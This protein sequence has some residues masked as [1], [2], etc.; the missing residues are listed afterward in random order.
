MGLGYLGDR[1]LR[2]VANFENDAHLYDWGPG[3]T[4][5]LRDACAAAPDTAAG[6]D[7]HAGAAGGS[8]KSAGGGGGGGGSKKNA[9]SGGGGS[10]ESAGSG[11]GGSKESAGS[12]QD[13]AADTDG[14]EPRPDPSRAA[15]PGFLKVPLER[16]GDVA[17]LRPTVA[18]VFINV[19]KGTPTAVAKA[20]LR[21]VAT[22]LETPTPRQLCAANGLRTTES[23]VGVALV[24]EDRP[25]HS[26]AWRSSNGTLPP[27]GHRVHRWISY[28]GDVSADSI[29]DSAPP[30]AQFAW[31]VVHPTYTRTMCKTRWI[32]TFQHATAM[33]AGIFL[34]F[35]G[36]A[37][38]LG[39]E[40]LLAGFPRLLGIEPLPEWA[41]DFRPPSRSMYGG[42]NIPGEF[43][44]PTEGLGTLAFAVVGGHIWPMTRLAFLKTQCRDA[45]RTPDP[46]SPPADLVRRAASGLA[47]KCGLKGLPAG[48]K[49][50]GDARPKVCCP[51]CV[52]DPVASAHVARPLV[53]VHTRHGPPLPTPAR[54][55]GGA[56]GVFAPRILGRPVVTRHSFGGLRFVEIS[57]ADG[58][59]LCAIGR[60]AGGSGDL[61]APG[62]NENYAETF[63]IRERARYL[64]VVGSHVRLAA[65]ESA[66]HE[67]REWI[68][69]PLLVDR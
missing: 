10:K 14:R 46:G 44:A 35:C 19:P 33:V 27:E 61:P 24:S 54:V 4:W 16:P 51:A 15:G 21:A 64:P 5:T 1:L 60:T 69:L 38:K 7:S 31:Y 53:G 2:L 12:G 30:S 37:P 18:Y 22:V 62:P 39:G 3:S 52:R 67:G 13:A 45:T 29:P 17:Y 56:H 41:R 50:Y 34:D 28:G 11:G 49:L 9:G 25:T 8:K 58:S 55:A 20:I 23:V 65:G 63:W 40:P 47:C 48:W 59:V 36:A 42:G 57:L 66:I 26:F 68:V 43:V 32:E 6:G